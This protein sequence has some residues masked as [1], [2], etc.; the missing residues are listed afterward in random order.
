MKGSSNNDELFIIH[1]NTALTWRGGEQQVLYLAEELAR[2]KV[3]QVV[4]CRKN[5][6]LEKRARDKNIPVYPLV[7][8]G[9]LDLLSAKRMAA[10]A[11]E[12]PGAIFH[13]HTAKAH[14][15]GLLAK[16]FCKDTPLLISRRVDFPSRT[17]FLSRKKYQSPNVDLYLAISENVKRILIQ[18][19]IQESKIRIAY[20]GIDLERFRSLPDVTPLMEEFSL[21]KGMII[22]GNV[23]ACAD[24][25]DQSTL[26]D[27]IRLLEEDLEKDW[28]GAISYKV[29]IVGEGKLRKSLEEKAKSFDLLNRRIIFTGFR[30][31]VLS[32]LNLF[33]IFI[34]SSK[35]EG[36]GTSVLDA[37]A[38]G[39]PVAATAGGG[40]PEMIDHDQGGFLSPVS[41]PYQ[42]AESLKKLVLSEV[43]RKKFG[44]YNRERVNDF[45]REQ[46]ARATLNVY[47]ELMKK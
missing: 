7:I 35:E 33:D 22:L 12:R 36:L 45:R 27:A 16:M 10:L 24:H 28:A 34:M 11:K 14:S 40:I 19:G 3:N 37:M 39:L 1:I 42:L 15:L 13:A 38:C 25:K 8:L 9:E 26:I 6:E 18:D 21:K 32:F 17:N 47:K 46:T 29:F 43:L 2:L 31:D 41:D 4:V 23:A 30:N 44:E 5:S 20:S